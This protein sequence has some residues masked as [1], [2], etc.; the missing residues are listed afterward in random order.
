MKLYYKPGACSMASHI[1][2]NETNSQFDLEKT[3][4]QTGLTE[5][6]ERFSDINPNGYVPALKTQ[7][8]EVI[9]ENPA[10]LQFLG[11]LAP[12]KKLTPQN[13]ALARTRL[14][15]ILNFI[16]S[17][18]HPAYGPFFS[19]EDLDE[20]TQSSTLEKIR[21]KVT[22]IENKLLDGRDYLLGDT[23]SVA[24]AYAFVVLNWSN[25]IKLDLTPWPTITAYMSR[26]GG[27]PSVVKAMTTEG[28]IS[29]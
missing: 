23:F 20:Q 22:S 12:E 9:T 4:T 28:L 8:G 25:F 16:S 7:S 24:D 26:I 5:N 2:L 6:G 18:L 11:D 13:D 14:H 21:K 15:E 19:G 3:D 27:R 1:I 29:A 17:E 10:I